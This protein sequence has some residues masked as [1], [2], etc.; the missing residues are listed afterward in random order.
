[1]KG[2]VLTVLKAPWKAGN[3]VIVSLEKVQKDLM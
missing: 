2:G 1:M 3:L